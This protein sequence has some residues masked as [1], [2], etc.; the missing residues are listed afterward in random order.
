MRIEIEKGIPIPAALNVTKEPWDIMEIGDSIL[1]PF[2]D[3]PTEEEIRVIWQNARSRAKR[4]NMGPKGAKQFVSR[5][6]PNGIR[7]WRVD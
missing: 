6:M 4:H 1:I 3:N 5:R 7:Y 2:V